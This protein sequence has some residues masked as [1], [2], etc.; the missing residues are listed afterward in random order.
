MVDF[1]AEL[2]EPGQT[3]GPVNYHGTAYTFRGVDQTLWL[4]D[5]PTGI[6]TEIRRIDDGTLTMMRTDGRTRQTG[7]G[8]NWEELASQ[9]F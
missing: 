6:Q 2:P 3:I 7:E 1:P 9:Y 4:I 5:G 8:D